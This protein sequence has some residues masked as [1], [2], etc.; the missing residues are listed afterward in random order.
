MDEGGGAANP[1]AEPEVR[2]C[3]VLLRDDLGHTPVANDLGEEQEAAE[4]R[5][6]VAKLPK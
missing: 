5:R 2:G 3:K 6:W 1:K 4:E